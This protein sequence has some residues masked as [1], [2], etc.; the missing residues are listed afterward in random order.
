MIS[1]GKHSISELEQ[2]D[3]LVEQSDGNSVLE[4]NLELIRG[5]SSVDRFNLV[6]LE[7][8]DILLE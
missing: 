6:R 8:S 2:S 5:E 1:S 3:V 4:L 7:H